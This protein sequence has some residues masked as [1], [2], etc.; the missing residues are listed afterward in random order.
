SLI[1]GETHI[2]EEI[3]IDIVPQVEQA[4]KASVEGVETTV[5]LL[6]TFDTRNPPGQERECA[7]FLAGLLEEAGYEVKEHEFG[8]GRTNL[9]ARL[10]RN[11]DKLPLCFSGHIDT[12]PLGETRWQH[13]PFSG[14]TDGDKLYGRGSTDMK[15]GVAAMVVAGLGL[16]QMSDRKAGI[17]FVISAGEE[18][19]CTGVRYLAGLD[20]VLGEAG[21]VVVGEP[22]SNEI[23]IGHKGVLW[24][25]ARTTGVAAHGA[26]PEEGESAI[27]KT[28]R[29]ISK[30][31]HFH[32]DLPAHP[33]LGQPTVN[34]GTVSGGTKINL[35]PDE[36][37]F[38]IDIRTVPSQ[39]GDG[40][41]KDL[42]AVLGPEVDL[43]PKL[44]ADAV[45][46]DPSDEWIQEVFA[47]MGKN[48]Q[49]PSQLRG[50]SYFTDAAILAKAYHNAPTIILGPGE[51]DMLHKTD[52]F[53]SMKKIETATEIYLDIARKWCGV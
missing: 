41:I 40:V 9:I 19:G 6:L 52:E 21:A 48:A 4:K 24:L 28:A 53:C 38:E 51:S 45:A 43:A 32:F 34:V 2:I 5:G 16:A 11:G 7:R 15:S 12:V 14:E 18:T 31:E 25:G 8:P 49:D 20:N 33:V 37:I 47:M 23:L 36:S 46:S 50:A 17:T 3:P 10:E 1:A 30:L 42:Q 39:T 13:D 35:V 29:A 44:S 27:Y 22:T 26:M